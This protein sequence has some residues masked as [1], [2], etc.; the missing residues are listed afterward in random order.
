MHRSPTVES[1]LNEEG[2]DVSA[3]KRGRPSTPLNFV[4]NVPAAMAREEREQR[5]KLLCQ[6]PR[7]DMISSR[8]GNAGQTYSYLSVDAMMA[9]ANSVWGPEGYTKEVIESKVRSAEPLNGG[10]DFQVITTCTVRI[11]VLASGAF[12]DGSGCGS[13]TSQYRDQAWSNSIKTAE[14][15]ATKRALS[16]FGEYLG[17]G[18]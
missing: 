4:N 18:L 5:A 17:L 15:D 11:T 1:R 10:R 8:Q 9:I 6:P 3:R 14:S 16:Q 2:E 13:N 12:R 7:P